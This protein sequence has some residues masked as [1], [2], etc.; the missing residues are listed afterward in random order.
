LFITFIIFF[1]NPLD[2][3]VSPEANVSYADLVAVLDNLHGQVYA[4]SLGQLQD[5][6][7]LYPAAHWVA[8]EDMIRGPGRSTENHPNTRNLLA[9]LLDPQRPSFIL[10]NYP[11][12]QDRML[13]FLLD[14]YVLEADFGD[15]FISLTVLPKRFN[16]LWPRYLYRY[17]PEEA[18][19]D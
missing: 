6:Y 10:T 1:Y 15:R 16:H 5:G 4:P 13:G 11:L 9:P 3:I 2:V 8:L 12:E 19:Q 17:A 18:A 14:Y 7:M